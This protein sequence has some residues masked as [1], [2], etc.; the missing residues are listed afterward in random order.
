MIELPLGVHVP[1]VEFLILWGTDREQCHTSPAPSE[2]SQVHHAPPPAPPCGIAH[3]W[4]VKT[5]ILLHLILQ[6]LRLYVQEARIQDYTRCTVIDVSVCGLTLAWWCLAFSELLVG[7]PVR[8]MKQTGGGGVN[9]DRYCSNVCVFT[10]C[11]GPCLS[12]SS[13]RSRFASKFW[14][15][16]SWFERHCS[17]LSYSQ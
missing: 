7:I 8:P 15:S 10:S 17:S 6:Q 4:P 5:W 11:V 3:T 16:R 14:F 9:A 2:P 1:W 13:K 12:L